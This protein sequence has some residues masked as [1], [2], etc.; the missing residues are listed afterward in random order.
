MG[1]ADER[2]LQREEKMGLSQSHLPSLPL[3]HG[4]SGRILAAQVRLFWGLFVC[5]IC[6][7]NRAWWYFR[8]LYII[9]KY[10]PLWEF[11]KC[12][13]VPTPLDY[14][15]FYFFK[16]NI[17][18]FSKKHFLNNQEVLTSYFFVSIGSLGYYITVLF[19]LSYNTENIKIHIHTIWYSK[20][21]IYGTI[22]LKWHTLFEFSK[23]KS[24][25]ELISKYFK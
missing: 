5:F 8:I 17:I 2:K 11:I 12:F 23:R 4:S 7:Q 13:H 1:E 18:I 21:I 10:Y 9:Y 6:D 16:I 15:P 24:E 3:S 14:D 22:L 25:I 19:W 20:Y